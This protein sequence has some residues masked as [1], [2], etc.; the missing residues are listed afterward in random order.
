[1]I[2]PVMRTGMARLAVLL[3]VTG[4]LPA[5]AAA[6]GVDSSRL[7]LGPTARSLAPGEGYLVFHGAVVPSFQVGLTDRV[8]FVFPRQ[9]GSV[10]RLAKK[11]RP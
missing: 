10:V 3:A 8:S 7:F 4:S 1:M 5:P 6:Q 2:M 9:G 11:T